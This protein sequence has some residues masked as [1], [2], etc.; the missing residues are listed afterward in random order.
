MKRFAVILGVLIPA[1]LAAAPRMTI[2]IVIDQLSAHYLPKLNPYLTGGLGFLYRKGTCF[3]NAFYDH[4]PP[5]TAAGHAMLATGTYAS[6]HGIVS[7][8]WF[9]EKG[10]V[11]DSDSDTA[12]NAAVFSPTGLYPFGKSARN[13]L[14]DTF[15]DQLMLHS[16]KHAKNTVWS[17]SLKGRSAIAMAGR[18]GKA[19][20]HDSKTQTFTSSKA[21]FNTLP[22]WV[23]NFK[24]K[25]T[26]EYTWKLV[27]PNKSSAY[28][29][30]FAHNYTYSSLPSPLNRL[31]HLTPEMYE[32][33]PLANEQLLQ[34]AQA[35]IDQNF[36]KDERFVLCLGL[37][38][39]DMVAHVYG[40][41]AQPTLDMIYHIDRQLQTFIDYVY[42]KV[43]KKDVLFVLTADH[44]VQPIPELLQKQGFDLA[45][46]Y[47]QTDLQKELNDLIEKSMLLQALYKIIVNH[48]SI[49]IRACSERSVVH[50]KR[51]FLRI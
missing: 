17:L 34:L 23:H 31:I 20:W 50:K 36:K 19:V 14:V 49:S 10:E 13:M 42:S 44:G 45:R 35:C 51:R 7:N 21:Y 18:L 9:N 24:K 46:R 28:D 2:V 16:Y 25:L 5:C 43:D 33:T 26:K 8:K 22:H 39:L 41:A 15:S 30:P 38:S 4:C 37:S 47:L 48:N 12:Q 1:S 32:G 27:Y 6:V 29:F 40:P 3:T 11:V